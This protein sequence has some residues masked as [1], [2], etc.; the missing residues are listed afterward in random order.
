MND[1]T[2][3]ISWAIHSL[4][5]SFFLKNRDLTRGQVQADRPLHGRST[6]TSMTSAIDTSS[7]SVHRFIAPSCFYAQ[8]NPQQQFALQQT[9][10]PSIKRKSSKSTIATTKQQASQQ[11]SP[12][13]QVNA[14]DAG[15]TPRQIMKSPHVSTSPKLKKCSNSCL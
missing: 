4:A 12:M 7:F 14:H 1:P 13:S 9:M 5:C 6:C 3:L 10:T 8:M 15:A 11:S 2:P